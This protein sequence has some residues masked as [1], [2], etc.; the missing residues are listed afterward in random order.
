MFTQGRSE[1]LHA[2]VTCGLEPVF[3]RHRT[4]NH[5]ATL[6]FARATA[7]E[8]AQV[9]RVVCFR[10]RIIV[11]QRSAGLRSEPKIVF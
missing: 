4:K 6:K 1:L 7:N 8:S 2:T 11:R 9:L 10:P 5:F 3:P